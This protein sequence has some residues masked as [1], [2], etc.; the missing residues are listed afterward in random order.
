MPVRQRSVYDIRMFSLPNTSSFEGELQMDHWLKHCPPPRERAKGIDWDVFVSYRSVESVWALALRDMLVQANY[1]VFLDQYV[2]AAGQGLA[3]TL[4]KHISASA[5]GVLVWSTRS[6]DSTWVER[7]YN[8]MVGEQSKPKRVMPFHLL[9]ASIDGAEPPGLQA[10]SIYID[11]SEY[12]DGPMGA[13]L[14]RLTAGLQ[15]QPPSEDAVRVMQAYEVEARQLPARIRALGHVGKHQELYEMTVGDTIPFTTSATLPSLAIDVLI[16]G[17]RYDLALDAGERVRARFPRS[18]RLRQL[19][20]LALRRSGRLED[21]ELC[22]RELYEEGERDPETLGIYA[23]V[24]ADRAERFMNAGDKRK[25][26]ETLEHARDL[27]R[28]GFEKVPTDTYTGI[29]AASKA[30][31]IGDLEDAQKLARK[32]LERL[33]EQQ[34]ERGGAAASEYWE[35]VTK[36]EALLLLGEWSEAVRLYHEARVANASEAGSIESTGKQVKRLLRVLNVPQAQREQ[37]IHEFKLHE[38]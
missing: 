11:F 8:Q 7:E 6:D 19:H 14:I 26:D 28:E 3:S 24:E 34:Q 9:V 2:L 25:S 29:N 18:I 22:M 32:V 35:R 20:G 27:Y 36:P 10:G 13:D 12:P 31:M 4:S 5:S 1:R 17:K 30:A 23:A 38:P 15:G 16:R 21:A 33:D 37:L